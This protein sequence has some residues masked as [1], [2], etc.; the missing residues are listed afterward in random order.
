MP[1]S[2]SVRMTRMA[3]S[4][5]FATSTFSNMAEESKCLSRRGLRAWMRLALRRAQRR[6]GVLARPDH[7][8][9]TGSDADQPDLDARV[10]GDELEV[11]ACL[12]GEVREPATVADLSLEARQLPVLGLRRME[13]G[14]VP[15]ELVEER[16]LTRAIAHRDVQRIDAGEHVQLRDRKRG[17]PVE[18]H[19]VAQRHQVE[20]PAAPFA[21]GRR[22]ALA[23]PLADER[24]EVV[25]E[26]GRKRP[27]ANPRRVCLRHAPYLVDVPRA[28][29]GPD[30]RGTGNGVGGGDERIRAV[31]EVE[32][33]PLGALEDHGAPGI[34][35]LPEDVRGIRD[36]W[37]EAMAIAQVLLGH[38]VEIEALVLGEGPQHLPL[39]LQRGHDLLAQDLGIEQVLDADP[40]A[41][42]LVGIAGSDAALRRPDLELAEP[43]LAR[44]VEHH[45]VR[46][47]QVRVRRD[48]QAAYLDAP[49][50]QALELADQHCGVDHDPVSDNAGLAGVEDPGR[51]QVEL[52]LLAVAHDRMPGVVAALKAHDHVGP[53]GEQVGELSLAL[54]APLGTHDHDS[55]HRQRIMTRA[56]SAAYATR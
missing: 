36:V 11:V 16:S 39:R 27:R 32:E 17:E 43:G 41:G 55:G 1:I 53:L 33:R 3:I 7:L 54:V 15:G 9:A 13:H 52:E 48:P 6:P 20:P 35:R 5:R 12:S 2:L 31:V 51:D 8:V 25:V 30:A 34:Q 18:A 28:N 19:G 23:A 10:F 21:A 22:A 56:R 42:R 46:H 4:P 29:A 37:L 47:D 45:V 40:Q 44:G 24:A 50:S 26:L 38:R 49:P 14:L